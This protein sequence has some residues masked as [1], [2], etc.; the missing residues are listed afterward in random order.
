MQHYFAKISKKVYFWLQP[1]YVKFNKIVVSLTIVY[2]IGCET[3][4]NLL[5]IWRFEKIR[6]H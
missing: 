1:V 5:A 2:E 3:K 6:E 4:V